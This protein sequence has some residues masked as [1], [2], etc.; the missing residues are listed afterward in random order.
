[1]N[2]GAGEI[3]QWLKPWAKAVE[4]LNQISS[5]RGST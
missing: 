3:A 5:T 4:D 1:M 2:I